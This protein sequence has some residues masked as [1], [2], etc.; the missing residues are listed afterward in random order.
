M[1]DSELYDRESHDNPASGRGAGDVASAPAVPAAVFQP[2][3]VVFQPPQARPEPV[4]PTARPESDT[5]ARAETAGRPAGS[6]GAAGNGES[7]ADDDDGTGAGRRRRRRS[8]RGRGRN[9]DQDTA[10]EA[11]EGATEAQDGET[12]RDAVPAEAAGGGQAESRRPQ[13]AQPATM[14]ARS[15]VPP[16]WRPRSSGAARAG[17]PAGAARPSLPSRSSSPAVSRSSGPWWSASART[18][19]RS[20]C[21]R[22]AC[23]S[24]TT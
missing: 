19:P 24:S 23:W 8:S 7:A 14:S 12:G 22:T 18:A 5:S 1:L 17:R 15:R 16:G 11:G 3:Q 13:P 9:G 10:A 6:A 4:T 20:R 21:S 2:P